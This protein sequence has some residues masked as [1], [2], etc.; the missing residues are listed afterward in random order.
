[1]VCFW[2]GVAGFAGLS[3]DYCGE[4][5]PVVKVGLVHEGCVEE[6]EEVWD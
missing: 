5:M 1:M 2:H 3:Q 6:M 4:L